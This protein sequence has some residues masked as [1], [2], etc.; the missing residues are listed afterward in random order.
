MTLQRLIAGDDVDL[1]E[2]W[3]KR[4]SLFPRGLT[5]AQGAAVT[6]LLSVF[7]SACARG[8]LNAQVDH[9]LLEIAAN[10]LTDVLAI[11]ESRDLIRT[12]LNDAAQRRFVQRFS[13]PSIDKSP[14]QP[15]VELSSFAIDMIRACKSYADLRVLA[16]LLLAIRGKMTTLE[17]LRSLGGLAPG[18]A[19]RPESE[20]QPETARIVREKA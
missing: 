14:P 3:Q 19:M 10:E 9:D 8:M 2:I 17:S 16:Q 20:S 18:K 4:A 1:S 13:L 15:L 12:P 5:D 6:G 7:A 11:F